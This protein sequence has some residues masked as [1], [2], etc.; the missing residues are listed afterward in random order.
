[1]LSDAFSR[2]E[3]EVFDH[4]WEEHMKWECSTLLVDMIHGCFQAA[5]QALQANPDPNSCY[6]EAMAARLT[7]RFHKLSLVLGLVWIL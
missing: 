1:M 2:I 5:R 4:M 6:P 7:Y 3:I